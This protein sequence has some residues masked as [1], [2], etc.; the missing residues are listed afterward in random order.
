[1]QGEHILI[2]L[3]LCAVLLNSSLGFASNHR[4]P[5]SEPQRASKCGPDAN[6]ACLYIA[7][8]GIVKQHTT[9]K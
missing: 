2:Q 7:F 9:G 5:R 4:D 6:T 3:E 1:M 8:R